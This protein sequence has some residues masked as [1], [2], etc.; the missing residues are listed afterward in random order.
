MRANAAGLVPARGGCRAFVVG[1]V[2]IRKG[3]RSVFGRKRQV[4][5][6][7]S[8]GRH[9]GLIAQGEDLMHVAH[10]QIEHKRVSDLTRPK[11]LEY[12]SRL[13]LPPTC[14]VRNKLISGVAAEIAIS[15]TGCPIGRRI[16]RMSSRM[17][18]LRKE[19]KSHPP[20]CSHVSAYKTA[21]SS[22]CR[23]HRTC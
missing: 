4:H 5:H 6:A 17:P 22:G 16:A 2:R 10:T 8:A 20:A 21:D 3:R 23:R 13:D 14:L 1:P 7:Y 11:A 12:V 9:R 19:S 18:Y 15:L